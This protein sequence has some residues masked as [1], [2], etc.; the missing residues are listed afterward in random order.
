[1]NVSGS[2]TNFAS[3]IFLP[4]ELTKKIQGKMKMVLL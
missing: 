2:D 3:E 4:V 1:M